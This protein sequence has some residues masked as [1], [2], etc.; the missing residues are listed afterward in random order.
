MRRLILESTGRE[1]PVRGVIVFSG[2]FI[3]RT[4]GGSRDICVLEPKALPAFLQNERAVMT[5]EHVN[6]ANYH[7]SRYVRVGERDRPPLS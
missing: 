7:L 5:A 4:P 6:L 2:W 3:E 1:F